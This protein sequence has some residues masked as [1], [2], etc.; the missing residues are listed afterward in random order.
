MKQALLVVN[1]G[2]A[3]LDHVALLSER[4]TDDILRLHLLINY[5][6]EITFAKRR[7]K[8][9]VNTH[10]FHFEFTGVRGVRQNNDRA[11]QSPASCFCAFA[12]MS[13]H[14]QTKRSPAAVE[15]GHCH[16]THFTRDSSGSEKGH[17]YAC[18]RQRVF[19]K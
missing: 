1:T 12:L 2:D 11:Q 16:T 10:V 9:S 14:P 15:G 4:L 18:G 19:V 7:I 13:I 17:C 5:E 3:K 6:A 8:F